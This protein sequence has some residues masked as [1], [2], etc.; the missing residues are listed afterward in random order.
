MTWSSFTCKFFGFDYN[1]LKLASWEKRSSTDPQVPSS[2]QKASL[3][4][5]HLSPKLFQDLVWHT[6]ITHAVNIEIKQ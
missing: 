4:G 2:T 6:H 1:V 3:D 5:I